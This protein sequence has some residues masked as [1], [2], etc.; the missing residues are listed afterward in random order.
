MPAY[1]PVQPWS[2]DK[3]LSGFGTRVNPFH[4]GLYEHPGVDIGAPRGAA[5]NATAPGV[6]TEIKRSTVEAGY[7]NFIEIDHGHG[8]R[9]RYAHLEEIKVKLNQRIAKGAV[10]GTV[11][12]SGGS[13]APHLHYEIIRDGKN[14]DPVR[15]MIEGLSSLEH[16][17]L[18]QVSKKHN[19][20]LD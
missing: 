17:Q 8:F 4:K 9:T 5:V 11:G 19:Q 13:I 7:G 20:S 1:Q 12:N 2:A 18:T 3:V 14:V 6:V 15:Y 10:I 16:H